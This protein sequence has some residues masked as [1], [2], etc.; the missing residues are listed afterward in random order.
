MINPPSNLCYRC[1]KKGILL[2][3]C[4]EDIGDHDL[5]VSYCLKCFNI[6]QGID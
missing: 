3:R 6:K 5:D 1:G 2:I 4:N